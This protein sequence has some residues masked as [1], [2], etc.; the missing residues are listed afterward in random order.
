MATAMDRDMGMGFWLGQPDAPDSR[1]L[2]GWT[3]RAVTDCGSALGATH[4]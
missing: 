4:E 1:R 2:S 3:V